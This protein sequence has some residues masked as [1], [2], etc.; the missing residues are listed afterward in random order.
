[1]EKIIIREIFKNSEYAKRVIPYL[2]KRYFFEPN[3]ETVFSHIKKV[4]ESYSIESLNHEAVHQSLEADT[5]LNDK[6]FEDS[7]DLLNEVTEDKKVA[8][9]NW[10]IDQTDNFIKSKA[11]RLGVISAIE[12][13]DDPK[14]PDTSISPILEE[15]LTKGIH[16]NIGHDFKLDAESRYETYVDPVEKFTTGISKLDNALAGGFSR[17]TLNL[18]IASVNAGKSLFLTSIASHLIKTH[19]VLYI[20]LEMS[21]QRI[22]ERVD[23]NLMD[24]PL[25]QLS[26]LT[27]NEYISKFQAATKKVTGDFYV[28]EYPTGGAGVA[29]FNSL[30]EELRIKKSFVPDIVLVDY[31][32]IM[33]SEGENSYNRLKQ[34][35]EEL[36]GFAVRNNIPVISAGQINRGAMKDTVSRSPDMTDVSESL[37]LAMTADSMI[38]MQ[39]NDELRDEGH[40]RLSVIKNRFSSFKGDFL[41]DISYEKM[42][43]SDLSSSFSPTQYDP[44]QFLGKAV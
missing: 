5:G 11:V 37:G 31:L 15:A 34:T 7:V 12:I 20:T 16:S 9:I 4:A 13:I 42:K 25:N 39:S 6:L 2:E 14:K 41:C 19:N 27:K 33:K 38:S 36:R 29:D 1:M 35:A 40:I 17:K 44:S 8:E 28:K 23:A 43:I 10:L 3:C 32:G 30:I 26:H 24:I 18:I 22:A 21:E